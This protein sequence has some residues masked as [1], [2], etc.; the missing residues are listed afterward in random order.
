MVSVRLAGMPLS[1]YP[2]VLHGQDGF[3]APDNQSGFA[4]E[5]PRI[6][7]AILTLAWALASASDEIR[8]GEGRGAERRHKGRT[9]KSARREIRE[10]V[11]HDPDH[12][13]CERQARHA[14]KRSIL[15]VMRSTVAGTLIAV[16]LSGCAAFCMPAYAEVGVPA[17]TVQQ[18]AANALFLQYAPAPSTPGIV[19]LVDSGVDPNPDTTPILVGSHALSSSTGTGDELAALDPPLP[20]GHPDGHGTY[21]AMVAAAPANGWGMVGFAPTSVRVFNLKALATGQTTFSFAEYASAI[22]YCQD[23]TATMPVSVVNLSL[24]SGTRPS[25]AEVEVLENYVQAAN[26]SGLSVVA[27]AGNE[28]GQVQAPADVPGVLGVGASEANP[29]NMGVMC[30]FSNSGPG[31]ALFAPGCDSQTL[32]GGGGNG[33]EIAFADT[34][35]PAWANGTSEASVIVSAVEA[36]MRAYSPTLTYVQAQGC[37]TSTLTG[38]VDLNVAAAFDAC[39]LEQ[40]VNEGMAAYRAANSSTAAPQPNSGPPAATL[41][42]AHRP[43]APKPK[44]VKVRFKRH[45]LT[46]TVA[47]IPKGLR[48]RLLVQVKTDAGRYVSLARTTTTHTTNTLRVSK[49]QRIVARFLSGSTELPPTFVA[50][51]RGSNKR[52]SR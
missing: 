4:A 3:Q 7:E 6:S 19:C 49:W 14:S 32:P 16:V 12:A 52:G 46:I 34:G 51:A 23:L 40:I 1:A 21:M 45:R 13:P 11:S 22:Q 17:G 8:R 28:G 50:R 29:A 36:S 26:A 42:Q 48:L 10:G 35:E 24:G 43:S 2:I 5:T 33:I 39:G 44:I 9:V 30:S 20:G 41:I 27:A 18:A 37:I 15:L 25:A 38:E 47:A 31:L